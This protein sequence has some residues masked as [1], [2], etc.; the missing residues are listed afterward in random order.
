MARMLC[1][2]FAS[3]F[4]VDAIGTLTEFP[5]VEQKL[6]LGS[7]ISVLHEEHRVGLP[8]A[9]QKLAFADSRAIQSK[10]AQNLFDAE[11]MTLLLTLGLFDIVTV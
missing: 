2:N 8:Q 3:S 4:C 6:A 11:F 1:L 7:I 5:H 10:L 9:W